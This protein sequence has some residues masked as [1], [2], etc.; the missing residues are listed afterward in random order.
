VEPASRTPAA[1][2]RAD[3]YPDP[4]GRFE[5]R[6]H[7][8]QAWTGDVS[9]DGNRFL[10][11]LQPAGYPGYGSGSVGPKPPGSGKASAALVLGVTSFLLGWVPFLAF[12]AVAGA[13][14]AFIFGVVVL[15]RDTRLR[16][17]GGSN[18][19]GHGMA[20]AGLILSPL[21]LASAG[22]GIWLS[23][24]AIR[25]V[26]TFQNVGQHTVEITSCAV[27]GGVAEAEGTI[28]NDES[29]TKSYHL[30][31]DFVLPGTDNEL[32]TETTDIDDV[33][34]GETRAWSVFAV[35][36]E[37]HLECRV[38]SVTGPLPFGQS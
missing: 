21:A 10:D 8:G 34:S 12:L 11:P 5:F 35:V 31:I 30:G 15:R 29:S 19:R 18:P 28:T 23:V 26:D 4:T 6:Y 13:V 32:Y 33:A 36:N 1:T 3:W 24:L 16:A 22:L 38:D 9:V 2:Y 37:E 7:N 17:A 20:L 27:S 14:L 25:E